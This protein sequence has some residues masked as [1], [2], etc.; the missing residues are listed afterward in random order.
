MQFYKKCGLKKY[1]LFNLY[2]AFKK[3]VIIKIMSMEKIKKSDSKRKV[4]HVLSRVGIYYLGDGSSTKIHNV[5]DICPSL[6]GL[7]Y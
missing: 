1:F 2:H 5:L 7:F 4:V 3:I 6:T